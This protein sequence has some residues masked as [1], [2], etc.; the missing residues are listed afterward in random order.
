MAPNGYLQNMHNEHLLSLILIQ[1]RNHCLRFV[2]SFICSC[3]SNNPPLAIINN[4]IGLLL[5][6]STFLK[7][8]KL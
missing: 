6:L 3:L 2:F 1:G 8:H 5:S 7:L 4:P